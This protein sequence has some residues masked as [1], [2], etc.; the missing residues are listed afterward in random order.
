MVY[1]QFG[2][3]VTQPRVSFRTN[4]NKIVIRA[5]DSGL[6]G[7]WKAM[8]FLFVNTERRDWEREINKTTTN[9]YVTEKNGPLTISNLCG[10][11]FL[12]VGG[13][14]ISFLL[15]VIEV[16]QGRVLFRKLF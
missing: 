10:S 13:T 12:L 8:D 11:F 5:T 6:M 14:A 15:F 16:F 1:F 7:K 4:L 3:I 9:D 2:S